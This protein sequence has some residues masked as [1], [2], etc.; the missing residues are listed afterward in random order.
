MAT[1]SG[2]LCMMRLARCWHEKNTLPHPANRPTDGGLA[3]PCRGGD[4]GHG[5]GCLSGHLQ[6][7]RGCMGALALLSP[8][9]WLELA[10]VA[11]IGYAGWYGYNWVYDRGAAHVQAQWDA[12]TLAA[13]KKAQQDAAKLQAQID[14][15]LGEKNAR[16]SDIN[17]HLSDALSQLRERPARPDHLSQSTG[18]SVGCTGASLYRPD[19]EFLIGESARA[20]RLRVQLSACQAAYDSIR[21]QIN[22][23]GK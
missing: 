19:A 20:D 11:L 3:I 22:G 5:M 14:Q 1:L 7:H 10:I 16:I 15:Q 2:A 6:D 4:S 12:Q 8:R 21:G 9:V 23:D 17:R 18:D 13:V